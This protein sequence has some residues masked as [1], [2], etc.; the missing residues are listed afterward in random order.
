MLLLGLTLLATTSAHDVALLG[1]PPDGR[2]HEW[3][4][5]WLGSYSEAP[6]ML[7]TRGRLVY[8]KHDDPSKVLWFTAAGHWQAGRAPDIQS[9]WGLFA[10]RDSAAEAPDEVT[11]PWQIATQG[12]G[13]TPAPG[14]GC[15]AAPEP[16]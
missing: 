5:Q 1:E 4:T 13:W 15:V 2:D 16:T 6:T 7:H 3:A 12:K 14:I 11:V 8:Q 10:S 9:G